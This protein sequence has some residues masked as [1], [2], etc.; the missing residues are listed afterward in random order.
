MAGVALNRASLAPGGVHDGKW[1]ATACSHGA[2]SLTKLGPD[3]ITLC[4]V[5]EGGELLTHRHHLI[6]MRGPYVRGRVVIWDYFSCAV[7]SMMWRH[8]RLADPHV[9]VAVPQ[10]TLT[11]P[12]S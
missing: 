5:R 12:R 11:V 7:S 9:T 4:R 6:L 2:M 3:M 10:V 1:L 8:R